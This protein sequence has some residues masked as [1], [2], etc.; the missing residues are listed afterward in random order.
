MRPCMTSRTP[1][2][3]DPVQRRRED[4]DSLAQLPRAHGPPQC[5]P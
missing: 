5:A 4:A 1:A 2:V 3:R